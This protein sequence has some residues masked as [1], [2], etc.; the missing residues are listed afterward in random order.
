MY[1][2]SCPETIEEWNAAAK[3]RNC[4]NVHKDSPFT[5]DEPLVYHYVKDRHQPKLLEEVWISQGMI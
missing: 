4:V 1:A 3:K 5:E 2:D